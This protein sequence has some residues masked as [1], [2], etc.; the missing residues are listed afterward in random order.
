M[1]A[2]HPS[3]PYGL[4]LKSGHDELSARD[5]QI[6]KS[7]IES[8]VW[9]FSDPCRPEDLSDPLLAKDVPYGAFPLG[10][11]FHLSPAGPKLIEI[12]TNAAGLATAI[13]LYGED[14]DGTKIADQFVAAILREYELA[15]RSG[16]PGLVAI[17][18]D[19]VTNQPFYPEMRRLA[20]IL[21]ERGIR[22]EVCDC[23]DLS[24]SAGGLHLDGSRVDLVYNRSVDF[25]LVDPPHAVL[26]EAAINGEIVLT[27]HPAAYVRIADKRNLLRLKHPV[28]PES[29]R[30]S[31][32]GIGEWQGDRK[33]WVFKPPQGSAAKGVYRGDKLTVNKL[34]TLPPDTIVQKIIAPPIANDGSKYDIRVYTRDAEILAVVARHYGGQVMEMR[35]E[36]A[37]FRGVKIAD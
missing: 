5:W 24:A 36:L 17:A 14:G 30:F 13:R 21:N 32:R 34:L 28:N 10:F 4:P 11:D 8:R 18:D 16:S 2:T 31:Q 19:D 12:N 29:M 23:R 27:P 25:R 3:R 35:S 6:M 9:R 7:F 22:T 26:R 37:G 15:G 33:R 20:D 1:Q